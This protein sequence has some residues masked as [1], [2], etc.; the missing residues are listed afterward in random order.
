M[1]ATARRSPPRP[2]RSWRVARI[3]SPNAT[4]S[5]RSSGIDAAGLII[6]ALRPGRR[7][8]LDTEW[9]T[10]RCRGAR[11]VRRRRAGRVAAR[12][13]RPQARAPCSRLVAAVGGTVGGGDQSP[14]RTRHRR[15]RR[16]SRRSAL[17]SGG[18][19]G[20]CR[21][22]QRGSRRL[23]PPPPP[24]HQRLGTGGGAGPVVVGGANGTQ[25]QLPWT[26]L[27]GGMDA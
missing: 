4:S 1:A 8:H 3:S 24:I 19:A 16:V 15:R 18:L 14:S 6:T 13:H 5:S 7:P 2:A 27:G 26:V 22:D 17:R 12:R 11:G 21:G 9:A 10:V 25:E 23:P 20:G